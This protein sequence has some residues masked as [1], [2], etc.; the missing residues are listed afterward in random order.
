[1]ANPRYRLK[2]VFPGSPSLN[3]IVELRSLSHRD[4]QFYELC[5]VVN[6]RITYGVNDVELD[7]EHWELIGGN[8][9][10]KYS[11]PTNYSIIEIVVEENGRSTTITNSLII[12][13]VKN[14]PGVII[15]KVMDLKS[16]KTL[17]VGDLLLNKTSRY[18]VTIDGFI[19]D[20]K[21]LSIKL[22]SSSH[23]I[24]FPLD[25]LDEYET[26][27]IV[28]EVGNKIWMGETAWI[29][30]YDSAG[31]VLDTTESITITSTN[32]DIYIK[33]CNVV[34]KKRDNLDKYLIE[35]VKC[36]SIK[37][38]SQFY[39]GLLSQNNGNSKGIFNLVEKRLN[40][41]TKK[42]W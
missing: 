42:T 21:T 17:T 22:L 28:D 10:T 12:N 32:Y 24:K 3:S 41:I 15:T 40:L 6:P 23:E 29:P 31:D 13:A 35:N 34:F 5:T 26:L 19:L 4:M 38:V 39:T 30:T 25:N 18:V 27:F 14:E 37:D 7:Q 16:N 8:P 36:L 9:T 1:M 20:K 2:K 33:R 11:N